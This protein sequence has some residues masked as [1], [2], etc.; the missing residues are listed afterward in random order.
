M[1][2]AGRSCFAGN[3]RRPCRRWRVLLRVLRTCRATGSILPEPTPDW[4]GTPTLVSSSPAFAT[5]T[6]AARGRSWRS[7]QWSVCPTSNRALHILVERLRPA[8]HIEK[9]RQAF[10]LVGAEGVGLTGEELFHSGRWE[11]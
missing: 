3:P 4:P 6:P 7:P 1:P 10:L 8:G 2:W 5:S 9:R 11:A